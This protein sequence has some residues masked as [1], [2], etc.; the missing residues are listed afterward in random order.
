MI[1]Q[2]IGLPPISTI[3]FGRTT[4]SS[5]RRVPSPPA[6]ITTFIALLPLRSIDT[7]SENKIPVN[8]CKTKLFLETLAS[9][10]GSYD[11]RPGYGRCNRLHHPAEKRSCNLTLL[12]D[13]NKLQPGFLEG[14]IGN[15]RY[16]IHPTEN[17]LPHS[18]GLKSAK[19]FQ[20]VLSSRSV[21]PGK[22][23]KMLVGQSALFSDSLRGQQVGVPV[24][25]ESLNPYISLCHEV[26]QI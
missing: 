21:E 20:V 17:N 2:R 5:L 13:L 6:R 10:Q 9:F 26:F 4:V 15:F 1:C 25:G 11:H 19:K 18:F 12:H 7:Y 24:T 22:V 3:G 16:L 14:E 8:P 23:G